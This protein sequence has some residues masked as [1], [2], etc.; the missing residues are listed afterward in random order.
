MSRSVE[1]VEKEATEAQ[2]LRTQHCGIPARG[3]DMLA[4]A[5][6]SCPA[7]E[8][9]V[10]TG[11]ADKASEEAG[12]GFFATA[13]PAASLAGCVLDD[14]AVFDCAGPFLVCIGEGH[15]GGVRRRGVGLNVLTLSRCNGDKALVGVRAV[16][17]CLGVGVASRW[18][19][20]VTE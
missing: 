3:G 4:D 20:L 19:V 11:A 5:V 18:P 8:A 13:G 12:V 6:G 7:S 1:I 15:L 16:C 14:E 9:P 2:R 17:T 10:G